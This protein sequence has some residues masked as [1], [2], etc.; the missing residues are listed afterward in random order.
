METRRAPAGGNSRSSEPLSDRSLA[1]RTERSIPDY[2][3]PFIVEQDVGRYTAVD[4]AVWTRH[5]DGKNLTGLVAHHDHG[6]QYLSVAYAEHLDAAGIKPSTGSDR[7]L[8]VRLF[9][10]VRRPDSCLRLTPW[11]GC[12]GC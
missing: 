5:R 11:F 10:A 3:Q 1:R 9:L 6:V 12:L 2:L 4:Q 7:A 8:T